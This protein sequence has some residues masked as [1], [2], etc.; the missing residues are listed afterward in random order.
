[1][2]AVGLGGKRRE[3][4]GPDGTYETHGTYGDCFRTLGPHPI[5]LMSPIGPICGG[6]YHLFPPEKNVQLPGGNARLPLGLL[7]WHPY[8][9]Y[10]DHHHGR[11][12]ELSA[13]PSTPA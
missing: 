6:V 9:S 10:R 5:S 7:I 4:R 2:V 11:S 13:L 3:G 1:M 8:I 12:R